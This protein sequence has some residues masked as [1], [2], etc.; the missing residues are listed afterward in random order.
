MT[1]VSR[2]VVGVGHGTGRAGGR[3]QSG[4]T[5]IELLIVLAILG[6]LVAVGIPTYFTLANERTDPQAQTTLDSALAIANSFYKTNGQ[7]YK[8]LC[9]TKQCGASNRKGIP[10]DGYMGVLQQLGS[11][12][13]AV[14]NP[15]KSTSSGNV[16]IDIIDNSTDIVIAAYAQGTGNCWALGDIQAPGHPIDGYNANFVG[17][18]HAVIPAAQMRRYGGKCFAGLFNNASIVGSAPVTGPLAGPKNAR[19]HAEPPNW[20]PT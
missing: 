12:P 15:L 4:L 2:R 8:Q 9:P 14:E 10:P 7:T 20:P 17:I 1:K 13:V 3:G 16:S 19:A 5:V 18:F 6:V 11:G